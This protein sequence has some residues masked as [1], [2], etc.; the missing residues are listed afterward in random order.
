MVV[1]MPGISSSRISRSSIAMVQTSASTQTVLHP[2]GRRAAWLASMIDPF[3]GRFNATR[4]LHFIEAPDSVLFPPRSS[5][6]RPIVKRPFRLEAP[7]ARLV[8]IRHRV[9]DAVIGYAP[10]DDADWKY[11]TDAA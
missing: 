8:W 1:L 5:F 7:Q 3:P 11:G 4:R 9:A 10:D 6:R 2:P